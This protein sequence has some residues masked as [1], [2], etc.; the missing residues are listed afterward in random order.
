MAS[1]KQRLYEFIRCTRHNVRHL[2]FFR[3][4]FDGTHWH[5]RDPDGLDLLFPFYPYLAALEMEGYLRQGG[6][7]LESGMTVLD[8]GACFGEF[9]LY[10]SKKVGASGRVLMLEPDEEN[11]LRAHKVFELNGGIPPH[12]EI[13]KIGLWREPGTLSFAAGN[14]PT[15]TIMEL[16]DA[17][18]DKSSVRQITVESLP[19][20]VQKHGLKR[21]DFVKMDIEGAEIEVIGAA[22]PV[23]DALHPRFSIASYHPRDGKRASDIL[24]PM[25]STYGYQATTGFETHLTTWAAPLPRK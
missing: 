11:L 17:T 25:F 6:W 19:S 12:V 13:L 16:S 9:A 10:A 3:I 18:T 20:L 22:R 1:L 4:R 14:G 15:S 23:T 8:V 5:V 2:K 7:P 24:E 21:L